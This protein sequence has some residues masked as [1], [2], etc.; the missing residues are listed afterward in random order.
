MELI[1]LNSDIGLGGIESPDVITVLKSNLHFTV[2]L[3]DVIPDLIQSQLINEEQG[4]SLK[5]ISSMVRLTGDNPKLVGFL[6]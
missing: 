5:K 3:D 6:A 1:K 2:F 4:K